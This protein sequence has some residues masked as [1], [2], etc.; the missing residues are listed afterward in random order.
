MGEVKLKTPSEL[1]W[2]FYPGKHEAAGGDFG[3]TSVFYTKE[4]VGI[5]WPLTGDLNALTGQTNSLSKLIERA[6]DLQG[7]KIAYSGPVTLASTAS[8]HGGH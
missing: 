7:Q 1:V 4:L 2:G 6:Y 5:G 8:A 3:S